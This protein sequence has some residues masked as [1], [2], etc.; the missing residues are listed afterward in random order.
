VA[1]VAQAMS[2]LVCM[3]GGVGTEEWVQRSGYSVPVGKCSKCSTC[4]QPCEIA[5]GECSTSNPC[6]GVNMDGMEEWVFCSLHEC[7]GRL[8]VAKD[9]GTC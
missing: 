6:T 1:S 7:N 8:Q 4:V 5:S 2:V 9:C 3:D